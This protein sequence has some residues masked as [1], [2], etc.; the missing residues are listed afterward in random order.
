[1]NAFVVLYCLFRASKW[2]IKRI[3]H[4]HDHEK[5]SSSP[6]RTILQIIHILIRVWLH[7]LSGQLLGHFS[8][9]AKWRQSVQNVVSVL[10]ASFLVSLC[11]VSSQEARK[12]LL[13]QPNSV[14]NRTGFREDP[15]RKGQHN[16]CFLLLKNVLDDK[17]LENMNEMR[18]KIIAHKPTA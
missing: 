1:M 15:T 5:W 14:G 3:V 10:L 6:I 17:H 8:R 18:K 16:I 4:A 9:Q 2:F 11:W 12:N 13:H 7:W